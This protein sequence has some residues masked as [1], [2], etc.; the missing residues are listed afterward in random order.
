MPE[1]T[2]A[3]AQKVFI[4]I[5]CSTIYAWVVTQLQLQQRCRLVSPEDSHLLFQ[6]E[7]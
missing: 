6:A 1:K 5:P 2:I 3:V 7:I 4:E